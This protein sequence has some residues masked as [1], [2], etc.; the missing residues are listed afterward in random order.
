MDLVGGR[1]KEPIGN[2]APIA[3]SG[4]WKLP[5]KLLFEFAGECRKI[6]FALRLSKPTPK[7]SSFGGN[8]GGLHPVVAGTGIFHD[9]VVD[10]PGFQ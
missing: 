9:L 3:V 5:T 6:S 8:T 10:L 4:V 7:L 1:F 2:F